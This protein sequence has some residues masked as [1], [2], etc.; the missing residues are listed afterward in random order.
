MYDP[1][2]H[3]RRSIRL[4]GHDYSSPGWYFVTLCTEGKLHVFGEVVQGEMHRNAAGE[5]VAACWRWLEKRHHQVKLDE[6]I[7]MPNHLHGII[8]VTEARG[9]SRTAPT[10]PLG[11]L[12][13]AFKTVSTSRVN[14]EREAPHAEL[15]QRD[16]Y[17]RII[18][19]DRELEMI[20]EYIRT[21][22]L[23]WAAD[24]ENPSAANPDKDPWS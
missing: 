17:E 9:G 14:A 8:V 5:M 24:P 13:G 18:R 22:P 20:R 7:V 12:I 11:R 15:W 6:W 3:H 2:I 21:N 1:R 16:F 10:K 19:H 23:R 4:R